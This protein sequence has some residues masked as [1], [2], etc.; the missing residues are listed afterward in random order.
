MFQSIVES[1]NHREGTA[2]RR[3]SPKVPLLEQRCWEA[4]R[5]EE[6]RE[7]SAAHG[8]ELGARYGALAVYARIGLIVPHHAGTRSASERPRWRLRPVCH[9]P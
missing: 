9:L 5:G 8:R 2:S 6:S 7:N 3:H 1:A 4:Q